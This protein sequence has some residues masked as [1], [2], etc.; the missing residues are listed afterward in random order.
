MFHEVEDGGTFMGSLAYRRSL[1]DEFEF[2]DVSLGEDLHF[3]DRASSACH[4]RRIVEGVARCTSAGDGDGGRLLRRRTL[5]SSDPH[6]A[7]R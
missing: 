3:A 1:V 5:G 6:S 4:T 7:P 2:A